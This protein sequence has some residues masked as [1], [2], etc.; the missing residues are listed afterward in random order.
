MEQVEA[1]LFDGDMVVASDIAIFLE[2]PSD[3]V[4]SPDA[5]AWHAHATLPLGLVLQ[6]GRQLELVTND[7]R[8][9]LVVVEEGPPT[10]ESA[11]ALHVFTGVGPLERRSR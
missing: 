1:T 8:S 10:I 6:P 3:D 11:R 2:A 4:G 9:G 5:S 7:G